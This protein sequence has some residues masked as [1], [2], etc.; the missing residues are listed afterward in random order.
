MACQSI[1]CA[2]CG[3]GVA[4][5]TRGGHPRAGGVK[6]SRPPPSGNRPLNQIFVCGSFGRGVYP[7]KVPRVGGS[8]K[9]QR[10][11][12]L[13]RPH[14]ALRSAAKWAWGEGFKG[15]WASPC[16]S[17]G[18][19]NMPPHAPNLPPKMPPKCPGTWQTATDANALPKCRS[20]RGKRKRPHAFGSVRPYLWCPGPESNRHSFRRG[21]LSPLRLP[22]S[23]PGLIWGDRNY[24]TF[25]T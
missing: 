21:I 20:H 23:P 9:V 25:R 12:P 7:Q 6:K 3:S 19:P 5:C 22:I 24:G 2:R 14:T 17:A 4:C 8:E 1:A 16:F 10:P 15:F 13:D 11:C 18:A